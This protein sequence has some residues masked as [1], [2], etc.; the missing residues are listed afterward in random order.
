MK[1]KITTSIF[2][3][4]F[5]T[6]ANAQELSR[7]QKIEEL[8]VVSSQV[9]QTERQLDTLQNRRQ[10]MTEDILSVNRQDKAEAERIGA[11][12]V[13]LFPDG[14]LDNLLPTVSDEIGFSVYSFTEISNYYDA[15]RIEYKRDK[16]TIVKD[17]DVIAFVANI[18]GTLPETISQQTREVIALTKYQPPKESK[19]AE[20]EIKIDG[21]TFGKSVPVIVGN[22]YIL[23]G[24]SYGGDGGIVAFRIH[25]KDSDGS[26][27]LFIKMIVSITIMKDRSSSVVEEMV[28]SDIYENQPEVIDYAAQQAVQEALIQKG[29]YNV[30]VKVTTTEVT[31]RGTVP[32]G[33]LGEAVQTAQETA[34]RKVNN[35]LTEK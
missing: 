21:L 19:D 9:E 10:K 27:V 22:T 32:K 35:Q 16:L 26:I 8:R 20:S 28:S 23:R 31:L 29:F 4:L 5:A 17:D 25:R 33:K 6:L 12:A 3:F 2:I 30:F 11:T 7:S 34:K 18:G 24:I 15:P 1:S 13:R 14:M